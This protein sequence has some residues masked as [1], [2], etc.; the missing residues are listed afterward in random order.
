MSEEQ[1]NICN[2][3][4]MVTTGDR[5]EKGAGSQLEISTGIYFYLPFCCHWH[6]SEWVSDTVMMLY[7]FLVVHESGIHMG[8]L[9]ARCKATLTRSR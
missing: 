6:Y 7:D 5:A 8:Q 2:E 9:S 4:Q 1:E 3:E